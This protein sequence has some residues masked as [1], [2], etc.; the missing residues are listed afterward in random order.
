MRVHR[1][2]AARWHQAFVWS[3]LVASLVVPSVAFAQ[4]ARSLSFTSASSQYV[5]F[6]KANSLQASS[7]TAE[8]WFKRTGNGAQ[9]STGNGGWLNIVPLVA[10]G[11]GEAET[12]DTLNTNYFLGIR[13]DGI[14][15]ADFEE[16]TG[17]NHP[18]GGATVITN[19]V[20]HHA[21]VIYN[22]S[23]GKYTLYLDGAIE[24]DTTLT[25]GIV[26]AS[27]SAQHA[28][29][30]TA[31]TS[32]GTAAGFFQG[33][34]DEPRIWNVARTQAEIQASMNV[35]IL[36]ANGLIGHWSFNEGT[37]STALCSTANGPTGALINAPTFNTDVAVPLLTATGLRFGSGATSY[38]TFGNNAALGLATFTLET[39][40]RRD[41]TGTPGQTGGGG[42]A[43]VIPL[44]T[45][46]RNQVESPANLNM[47]YYLGINT[48]GNVLC[49]DFEDAINGGNHPINGTTAVPA[50][51]V[52]HH[53]AVTYNGTTWR[54]YLD[55]NLEAT[56]SPGVAAEATSIQH[57]G[58][59]TGMT[60][61]GT[62]AGFFNGLMDEARIWNVARSQTQIQATMNSQLTGVTT[63]L[64]AR[65]GM[66]E[67]AGLTIANSAGGTITG[68]LN[69][70]NWSWGTSSPFNATLPPA[71]ADPSALNATPISHTRIDLSWIDNATNEAAYEVERSTT[72]VG[73]PYTLLITLPENTTSYSNTGLTA[74][75]EYC[76]RVRATNGG[77]GSSTQCSR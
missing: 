7:F 67:D 2:Q 15:A 14:L 8:C 25:G 13:S 18:I 63:N 60:S 5:T 12:P 32:N 36:S 26:P 9:T 22:S 70:T 65:Y 10:K 75:T 64:V 27:M 62:P 35:E 3:F 21:A 51:G 19:N 23:T 49:A 11:R 42:I 17:P 52:W 38:V 16:P 6:G 40:F 24:K 54:L 50:D 43:S 45:K 20:W 33:L 34:I 46:G 66:N 56:D 37:G 41:G 58:L 1:I 28:S 48:A 72:G 53:A 73:G 59:G 61:D 30:A 69:G 4:T 76:Y 68:T 44:I 31:M 55:G 39:W 71:P 74:N 77:G 57:A 29:I 47:N